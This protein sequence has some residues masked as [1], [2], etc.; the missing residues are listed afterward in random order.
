MQNKQEII[1]PPETEST[2]VSSHNPLSSPDSSTPEQSGSHVV[3]G[4]FYS[5]P[6]PPPEVLNGYNQVC[7]GAA[8]TIISAFDRQSR[9]RQDIEIREVSIFGRNSKW[10]ILCSFILGISALASGVIIGDLYGAA[11]V[12]FALATLAGIY[13]TGSRKNSKESKQDSPEESGKQM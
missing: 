11:V 3:V 6:L 9:H 5:G 2:T 12:I 1:K 13:I 8:K 7:P 10:G 4:S